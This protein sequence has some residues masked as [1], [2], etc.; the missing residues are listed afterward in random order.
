MKLFY[1]CKL[2]E[3]IYKT[4]EILIRLISCPISLFKYNEKVI[5]KSKSIKTME[6]Q[7][8]CVFIQLKNSDDIIKIILKEATEELFI[9]NRVVEVTRESSIINRKQVLIKVVERRFEN[10]DQAFMTALNA[11]IRLSLATINKN[12]VEIM[13]ELKEVLLKIIRVETQLQIQFLEEIIKLP[14]RIDRLTL[15]ESLFQNIENELNTKITYAQNDINIRNFTI[16][17]PLFLQLY[18]ATNQ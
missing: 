17:E 3:L 2:N 16:N 10:L 6:N 11:Y 14:K 4:T 12:V 13:L 9:N 5:K 7:M 15:L 1:S 18:F 8:D